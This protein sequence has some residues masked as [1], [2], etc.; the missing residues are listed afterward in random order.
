M[1]TQP[2]PD[3]WSG[4]LPLGDHQS[5]FETSHADFLQ[6]AGARVVPIDYT[7]DQRSLIKELNSINGIYI[8]GDTKQSY[9]DEQYVDQVRMI[10][11]WASE[12][13]LD[14]AKHFPVVGV[15]WGMLA[16]L[17]TQTT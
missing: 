1:L 4:S 16:M 3:E 14:E 5:F 7:L 10:L 15:S 2:L 8:P 6:A 9:E 12:H 11:E 17:K 13:N